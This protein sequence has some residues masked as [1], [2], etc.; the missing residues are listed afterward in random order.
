MSDLEAPVP[1]TSKTS[2]AK[3]YY[4]TMRIKNAIPNGAKLTFQV[5]GTDKDGQAI[6]GD[7][8]L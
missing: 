4:F 2:D 7:T 8:A 3:T 5:S 6:K 1:D